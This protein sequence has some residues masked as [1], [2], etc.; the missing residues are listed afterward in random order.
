MSGVWDGMKLVVGVWDG[1]KC[2]VGVWDGMKCVV[3]VWDGMKCVGG[4]ASVNTTTNR[5]EHCK[6]YKSSLH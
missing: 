6:S 2:V 5:Q 3:G 4:H 1:M